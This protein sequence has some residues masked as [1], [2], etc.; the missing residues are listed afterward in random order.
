MLVISNLSFK[1][2]HRRLF[3]DLSLTAGP[4]D[5]WHISGPNGVGKSTFLSVV[6][7]LLNPSSGEIT[8]NLASKR[9]LDRRAHLEYLPAEA[10]GLYLKMDSVQ[11]LRFWSQLRGLK[12]DDS[13]IF[14][15]LEPWGLNHPLL[16]DGFPIEKY[17]TGMKRRLALARLDLSPVP[18]WLLDEPLYG[19][20][21]Q[22]ITVFR[23]R[24]RQHLSRGGFA[25]LISHDLEPFRDLITGAKEISSR[26][27]A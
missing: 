13:A 10:N 4:G 15:A 23:E 18:G 2:R 16:R 19:L 17:S 26:G 27:S 14:A 5:L 1:F 7:G 8:L 22:A 12:L 24:L 6:A 3:N 20:D 25:L 21:Q 11:N 9:I